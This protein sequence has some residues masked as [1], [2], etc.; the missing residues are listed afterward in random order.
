MARKTPIRHDPVVHAFAERLREIRRSQGMTQRDLARRAHL[1]ESYLS[2]LE[3]AQIAPGV[4]LVA[5]IARAL[6]VTVADLVPSE[7]PAEPLAILED[8]ARHLFDVVLRVR[9]RSYLQQL[10]QFLALL[11]ESAERERQR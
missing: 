5:R 6:G 10:N 11:A 3:S 4:D 8:Q 2:R 1:T 7:P 9:D